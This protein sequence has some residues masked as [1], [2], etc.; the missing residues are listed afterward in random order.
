MDKWVKDLA[1]SLLWQIP[2]LAQELLHATGV[3]K[4]KKKKERK[5]KRK[6]RHVLSSF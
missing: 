6:I 1:L 5:K 2:S 3:A 4:K